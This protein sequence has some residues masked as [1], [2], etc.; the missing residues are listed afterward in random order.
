MLSIPILFPRVILTRKQR[1]FDEG[2]DF[3][4]F[5]RSH[6]QLWEVR[7]LQIAFRVQR[8]ASIYAF[9]SLLFKGVLP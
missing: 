7:E 3:S 6:V 9:L 5:D 2:L 4:N 1:F 8:F